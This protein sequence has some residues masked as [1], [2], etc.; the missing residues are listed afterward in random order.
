VAIS[1]RIDV[2]FGDPI[3]TANIDPPTDSTEDAPAAPV[4]DPPR[5]TSARTKTRPDG[6][7][8]TVKPAQREK[9]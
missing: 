9:E 5:R 3:P 4:P 2:T 8:S 1:H 7:S 6:G